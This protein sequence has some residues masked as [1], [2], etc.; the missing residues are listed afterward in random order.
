MNPIACAQLTF[1]MLTLIQI[2][3]HYKVCDEMIYPFPNFDGCPVKG[4]DK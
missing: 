2:Y 1:Q 4:R 3:T